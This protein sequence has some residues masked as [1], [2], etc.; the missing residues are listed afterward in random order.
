VQKPDGCLE[1]PLRAMTMQGP[2]VTLAR[3]DMIEAGATI[4]ATI[5]VIG[6]KEVNEE[7][8]YELL[9]YGEFKGLGQFRNGSYGSFT[10][11]VSK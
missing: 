10:F 7:L 4:D 6:H 1:R 9:G 11:E 3:S 8:L 2:R 5:R